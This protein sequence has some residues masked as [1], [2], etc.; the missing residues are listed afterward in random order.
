[1]DLQISKLRDYS[2]ETRISCE[3]RP[4]FRDL[5]VLDLGRILNES[6]LH[7]RSWTCLVGM[8]IGMFSNVFR[9]TLWHWNSALKRLKYRLF[10]FKNTQ[11]NIEIHIQ[12]LFLTHRH[13]NIILHFVVLNTKW[14]RIWTKIVADRRI[15]PNNS[16]DRR[17]CVLLFTPPPL[18][19]PPLS[20]PPLPSSSK[21][22]NMR[23][24]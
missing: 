2:G 6:S 22:T 16:T 23:N 11:N 1:M 5:T 15:G 19:S 10:F 9:T 3:F 8:L 18:P 17:I 13:K 12:E 4:G 21:L 24:P 20:S 14:I 7:C